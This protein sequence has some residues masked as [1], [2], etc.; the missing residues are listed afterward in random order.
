MYLVGD[1]RL[2]VDSVACRYRWPT[3][4]QHEP[5]Q[6]L[7]AVVEKITLEVDDAVRDL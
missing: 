1:H 7:D 3:S 2:T 4:A 6:V 5:A